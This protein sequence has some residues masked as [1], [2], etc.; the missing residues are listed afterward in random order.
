MPVRRTNALT[1]TLTL[2]LAIAIAT[3]PTRVVA[4][5]P[6]IPMPIAAG[7]TASARSS[8]RAPLMTGSSRRHRPHRQ[9]PIP[10]LDR[11]DHRRHRQCRRQRRSANSPSSR[12]AVL[13]HLTV[14]LAEPH[15]VLVAIV[16]VS[17]ILRSKDGPAAPDDRHAPREIV[18]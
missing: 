9:R 10:R 16:L 13:A 1:L 5:P 17:R 7:S 15:L 6:A 18:D 2:T 4:L 3:M 12:L 8:V 11:A 14:V